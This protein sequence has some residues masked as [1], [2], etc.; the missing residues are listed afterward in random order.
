MKWQ[1]VRSLYPD[2]FVKLKVLDFHI[3]GDNKYID[4]VAVI[5]PISD[6]KKATQELVKANDDEL[7]FHTSNEKIVVELR[8]LKGYTWMTK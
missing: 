7:V 3:K 6:N 5:C 8:G 1:E 2:Q 4:E